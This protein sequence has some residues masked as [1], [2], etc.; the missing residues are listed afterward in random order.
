MANTPGTFPCNRGRCNTCPARIP[1]LTFWAQTGNRFTVNQHFTCT[2]TNVV[3][4]FVCGRCSS[5]Y[6]GE[7]KRSLA[8]RVTEHLRSTK[9]NLPGY[10]VATH[11]NP[12]KRTWP[13]PQP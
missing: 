7:T 8:G 4:I 12:P 13:L 9:Q 10:P 5:L 11:F 6:A 3:Y 2:S 1:S